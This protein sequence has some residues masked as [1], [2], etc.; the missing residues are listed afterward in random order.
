M[1][2]SHRF[3]HA[4]TVVG[5]SVAGIAVAI[6]SPS[7]RAG[8]VPT[9]YAEGSSGD[10]SNSQAA[11]TS[12]SL[13]G[14]A[15]LVLGTVGGT[16]SQDFLTITV[17]SGFVLTGY[18][19]T[20]YR[21]TDSQGFTGVASG[22]T[23]SGNVFT[24]S[25]YLGYAHFGTSASNGSLPPADTTG[26]NLLPLMAD[27]INF[28]AGAQGFSGSLPAGSY[29]FLIQQLGASTEYAFTFTLA[30]IPTPATSAL[31]GISGLVMLRRRR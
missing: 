13:P 31:V 8:V 19:N 10:L 6:A 20:F 17:P 11:P 7:V 28:A 5:L 15:S 25:A 21:S 12:V 27:N 16:D 24:P 1:S 14:G 26:V 4:R 23:F 3:I 22:P 18:A 30:P 9:A 2:T 29:T